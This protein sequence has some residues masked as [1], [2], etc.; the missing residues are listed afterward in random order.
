MFLGNALRTIF[1]EKTHRI[2]TVQCDITALLDNQNTANEFVV[3]ENVALIRRRK[4]GI[5][6]PGPHK[7][8]RENA[9][10]TTDRITLV[11]ILQN[12]SSIAMTK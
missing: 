3:V 6:V 7:E 2:A 4:L 1:S 5:V 11:Q 12:G 8:F 9:T 10:L